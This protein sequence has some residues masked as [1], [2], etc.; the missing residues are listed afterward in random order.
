MKPPGTLTKKNDRDYLLV[1]GGFNPA[2]RAVILLAR[3]GDPAFPPLEGQPPLRWGVQGDWVPV[4]RWTSEELRIPDA[5]HAESTALAKEVIDEYVARATPPPVACWAGRKGESIVGTLEAALPMGVA[6]AC[7]ETR[8]AAAATEG[9]EEVVPVDNLPMFLTH[10]VRE[11]YAGVMWNGEQPVFFCVDEAGDLRFLRVSA[12]G[13]DG[14]SLEV[15]DESGRW[16]PY[17][18]DAELE[19]IDNG[20]ACDRRL[21]ESLGRRPVIDWPAD[22]CLWTLGP[23]LGI[24]AVVA[25]G[26][27]KPDKGPKLELPGGG[28]L[29]AFGDDEPE[30]PPQDLDALPHAVLFTHEDAA[31]AFRAE[32]APDMAVFPVRDLPRFLT[33]EELAGCFAALNPGAHRAATGILWSDGD[34]V[35]LDSFSGFWKFGGSGFELLE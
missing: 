26:G 18:G 7:H 4:A 32:M 20:E 22:S 6:A 23:T 25:P 12:V 5:K 3:P 34:R 27:S 29:A 16:L 14:V 17:E 1:E 13:D 10:L 21:I 9:V 11:G 24:P 30:S 35:V 31:K 28:S 2:T 15:L 33:S 19:F 8:E